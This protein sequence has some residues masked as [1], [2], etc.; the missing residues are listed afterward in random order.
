[1][2]T[3]PPDTDR[4]P[5]LWR[6]RAFLFLWGGQS[7]SVLG[8]TVS[9]IIIPV[10]AV[11]ALHVSTFEMSLLAAAGTLP[12]MLVGLMAG[13]VVDRYPRRLLMFW[14]DVVRALALASIPFTMLL[15]GTPTVAQLLA[16]ALTVGLMTVFFDVA[17][18]SYL[19]TLVDNEQLIDG[20]GKLSTTESV[21][22]SVGPGLAGMLI[23][24]LGR[25]GAILFDVATY[26]L[27]CLSLALI[28][29]PDEVIEKRALPKPRQII[30][31]VSEGAS[32]VA[33]NPILRKLAQFAVTANLF[34]AA[35]GSLEI[36]FLNRDLHAQAWMIG[37]AAAIGSTG[38][39]L[40][41]LAA[42]PLGRRIGSARATWLPLFAV[43]WLVLLIPLAQPGWGFILV[44]LGTAGNTASI[45]LYGTG[46]VSY[47]QA[48]CPPDLLSRVTAS[49]R[50]LAWCSMPAG[51]LL[52][53]L[54]GTVAGL[55]AGISIAVLGC[56]LAGLWIFFSPLRGLR[57]LP[58]S[59]SGAEGAVNAHSPDDPSATFDR[60]ILVASGS[61][62]ESSD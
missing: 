20:N 12:Y 23:T 54:L 35:Y 1:M 59:P 32:Y 48:I 56:F 51:A 33:R 44:G 21:A 27:S 34:C 9:G 47:R 43:G 45:V 30:R 50:W 62:H 14:C 6:N 18:S 42:A 36:V 46:A 5:S 39:V 26:V 28:K 15:S 24:V 55:R 4:R 3:P 11:L 19:P 57:D 10:Y 13:T 17:Y 22:E 25:A 7:V 38:G 40:G 58:S 2:D 53:G 29:T 8:S 41:G 16:V 37:A 60:E 61:G 31:E 52:G 49:Q